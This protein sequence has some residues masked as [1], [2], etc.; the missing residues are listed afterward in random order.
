MGYGWFSPFPPPLA[1][2]REI[3]SKPILMKNVEE[4][5]LTSQPKYRSG[6]V[7]PLGTPL[8]GKIK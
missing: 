8:K 4:N 3:H 6:A 1:T 2:Y 5:K 7:K